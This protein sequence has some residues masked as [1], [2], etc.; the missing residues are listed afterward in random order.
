MVYSADYYE[1]KSRLDYII[2]NT[3]SVFVLEREPDIGA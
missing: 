1:R 2:R 3:F